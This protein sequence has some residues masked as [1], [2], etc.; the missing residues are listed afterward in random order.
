MKAVSVLPI[1]SFAD[2]TP[3]GRCP[4]FIVVRG[5]IFYDMEGYKGILEPNKSLRY[6]KHGWFMLAFAKGDWGVIEHMQMATGGTKRPILIP[7][8]K[9]IYIHRGEWR[10]T[11]VNYQSFHDHFNEEYVARL[12]EKSTRRVQPHET[13]VA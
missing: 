8:K 10:L 6:K 13:L 5:I 9:R 3:F 4:T 11:D 2:G 1:P 12:R 7:S